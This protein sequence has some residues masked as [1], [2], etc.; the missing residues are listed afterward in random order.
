MCVSQSRGA[1]LCSSYSCVYLPSPFLASILS[2][3]H[4]PHAR[5]AP[6]PHLISVPIQSPSAPTSTCTCRRQAQSTR[7][8]RF[9]PRTSAKVLMKMLTGVY[10]K[11]STETPK[12]VDVSVSNAPQG[13]Y[14]DSHESAHS[15]FDC[16]RD[17]C[18]LVVHMFYF[19]TTLWIGRMGI[20]GKS[21]D[22]RDFRNRWKS[23]DCAR[24]VRPSQRDRERP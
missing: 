23:P 9:D 5:L 2:I 10:T 14:E 6:P 1:T 3:P 15:K 12:K 13:Q 18:R 22:T 16:G 20:Q 21:R 24:R 7:N 19:L 4:A 17:K 8:A 11:M